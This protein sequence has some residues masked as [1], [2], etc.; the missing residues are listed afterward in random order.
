MHVTNTSRRAPWWAWTPVAAALLAPLAVVAVPRARAAT[1]REEN[2]R[3]L[4]RCSQR[5][6]LAHEIAAFSADAG[7][8]RLNAALQG[9]RSLVPDDCPA[10]FAMAAIES[11]LL[12]AGIS[13]ATV[14]VGESVDIE[15]EAGLERLSGRR[16]DVRGQ[17]TVD[18]LV[19][20][21]LALESAVGP[22][23]WTEALVSPTT[24]GARSAEF[25][26]TALLVHRSPH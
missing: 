5:E 21:C 17:A 14:E 18:E 22:V 19:D 26:V 24:D 6:R 13:G 12:A 16:I 4:E 2:G 25:R 9:A 3:A 10:L 23:A 20:W 7:F 15:G 8:E 11:A 1:A